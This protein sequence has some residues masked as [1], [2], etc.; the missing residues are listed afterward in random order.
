VWLANRDDVTISIEA[1]HADL[2]DFG[3]HSAQGLQVLVAML[4]LTDVHLGDGM[5]S[6]QLESVDQHP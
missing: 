5:E 2:P 1:I 3:C 4:A 6:T